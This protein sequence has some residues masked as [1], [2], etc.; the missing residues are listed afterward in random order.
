[1][2]LG[3]MK[4]VTILYVVLAL[5]VAAINSFL[6]S[7]LPLGLG[8]WALYLIPMLIVSMTARVLLIRIAAGVAIVLM[9]AGLFTSPP[10]L[11]FEVA[12]INR[13]LGAV[14]ILLF[15][16]IMSRQ[17]KANA[18]LRASE[19]EMRDTRQQL[20]ESEQR[21]RNLVETAQVGV[22]ITR[23]DGTFEYVNDTFAEQFGYDSPEEVLRHRVPEIY[24]DPQEREGLIR[25]TLSEGRLRNYP[26]AMVT[27]QGDTRHMLLS[28]ARQ[29]EGLIGMVQDV[30]A[31]K[32]S[33]VFGRK[34]LDSSV[35]GLYVVDIDRMI[36][37]FI[38]RQYT[39]L[40]GYGLEDL[41]S[42]SDGI[43]RLFDEHD[44]PEIK[45]N[46]ENLREFADN[47][48]QEVEYRFLRKDGRWIW[49]A[50]RHA[51]FRRDTNGK[52]REYIGTFVDITERK[53]AENDLRESEERLRLFIE[54]APV[55]LAMFDKNMRYI[56]VSGRWL[57]DHLSESGDVIGKSYYELFP[58]IPERWKALHRRGLAGE[59]LQEKEDR[60]ER[61]D[62]IVQWLRWEIH[63]WYTAEG[64]I[65]GIVIFAEDITERRLAQEVLERDK[66]LLE[67]LVTAR[68]AELLQAR[69]EMERARRLA[70]LGELSATVAHELR[71]PLA[72]IRV[73]AVN[74]G[75]KIGRAKC[76]GLDV[77]SNL[78]NID[79]KVEESARI[80]NNMLFYTRLRKSNKE[81]VLLSQSLDESIGLAR[82]SH[83]DWNVDLVRDLGDLEKSRVPVD[84]VQIKELFANILNNAFDALENK[85]GRV[86]VT[87]RREGS[88]RFTIYVSDTGKGI[89]ADIVGRVFQ[90]FFTTKSKGTGLG[91]AVSRQIAE[92]HG[93]NIEVDSDEGRGT[94][95]SV[96]LPFSS[97][98]DQ[99]GTEGSDDS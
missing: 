59:V 1:M 51:V 81:W 90:P 33:E 66:E 29:G 72:A 89:P 23:L 46:V 36:P 97:R 5:T 77:T 42:F 28:V 37:V 58:D 44:I 22:F 57:S 30:T 11:P 86:T 20:V 7:M 43:F 65:G 96:T 14:M 82:S 12:L 70:D 95:V 99:S 8:G 45:R 35:N 49:C 83:P 31:L 67:R 27:K 47:D 69:E 41:R 40:T 38:N 84:P 26:L 60:V 79:K 6:D 80:I 39:Q 68:T 19:K 75:R 55:S 50:A 78:E 64:D 71:N 25:R 48:S 73:A 13:T 53:Q 85:Q 87:A 3:V 21:Y 2:R 56:A 93:G 76:Q 17:V 74:I 52:V 9:F 4:H 10:G 18:R 63:P 54:H 62:G 16:I 88:D 24:R 98:P 91:L 94:T 34:V 32:E 15:T 61:V 92:L